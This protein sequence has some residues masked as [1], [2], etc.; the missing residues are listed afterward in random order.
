[1]KRAW[2]ALALGLA[3]CRKAEPPASAGRPPSPV[4][5]ATAEAVDVPLYLD[6]IGTC[7]AVERVVVRPRVTGLITAVH[8][9]DG[10]EL[11]A[12]DP[13]FTIDPLPFQ[14]QVAAAEA[15]LA[16]ANAGHALAKV[17]AARAEKLL[18]RNAISKQDVD[19]ARGQ[20]EVSAARAK[21]AEAALKTARLR[22]EYCEIRS[23]L[24]GRAGRRLVDAGNTVQENDTELI[25]IQRVD[26]IYAELHVNEAEFADVRGRLAKGALRVEVR[27]GSGDPMPGELAF[28]DSAVRGDTGTV[29]LRAA[30]ANPGRRLWPGLF[31]KVRIILDTLS[32]AV[33]VPADAPQMS[34]KGPFVYV[35]KEDASAEL[36]PVVL[37]QK[38]A[39]RVVVS[40]GVKAGESVVV[41]GHIGV[42]PGGKVQVLPPAPAGEPAK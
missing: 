21:A 19:T 14:A 17:D 9:K 7:A 39:G 22:L 6:E 23:P 8:V 32:G 18:E 2:I 34:A 27:T 30:V 24:A 36:R 15:S 38:H 4:L 28:V 13:L 11:K 37:G 1:M 26:P 31:V 25:E 16:E 10:A 40:Q 20:A 5:A 12:G 35:I 33:L 42:M 29:M 41:T 3:A